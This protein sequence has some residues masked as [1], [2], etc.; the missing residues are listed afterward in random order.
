[1]YIFACA[2]SSQSFSVLVRL[3]SFPLGPPLHAQL[4]SLRLLP[5]C[6]EAVARFEIGIQSGRRASRLRLGFFLI[7]Q[8]ADFPVASPVLISRTQSELH[9]LAHASYAARC[10]T[11]TLLRGFDVGGNSFD[12]RELGLGRHLIGQHAQFAA[13]RFGDCLREDL[14]LLEDYADVLALGVAFRIP[15]ITYIAWSAGVDGM[16]SALSEGDQWLRCGRV[17][18][19]VSLP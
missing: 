18:D 6:S 5:P 2:R 7:L 11:T 1:M 4:D 10:G 8:S 15:V 3:G 13:A 16:V 9:I 14:I 17:E 19:G 12:V